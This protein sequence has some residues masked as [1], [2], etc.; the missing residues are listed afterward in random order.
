MTDR[1]D[2]A[3]L[4]A[5]I[6][7]DLMHRAREAYATA[8]ARQEEHAAAV[9]AARAAVIEATSARATVLQKLADG[10]ADC[11]ET[12]QAE[13]AVRDA[14]AH[15]RALEEASALLEQKRAAA[16]D[17]LM[18]AQRDAARPVAVHGAKLRLEASRR[19]AEAKAALAAA[20]SEYDAASAILGRAMQHGWQPPRPV[21]GI[22]PA[23]RVV[24]P[25]EAVT[26]VQMRHPPATE[27]RILA[28]AGLLP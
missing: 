21:P 14:E 5:M 11:A 19:L 27:E 28:D 23:R 3:A 25:S 6:D 13:Q 24:G 26:N 15:V 10:T 2:I 7:R 22:L 16:H 17:A 4:D 12:A 9:A 8:C 1:I 20:E 18:Q